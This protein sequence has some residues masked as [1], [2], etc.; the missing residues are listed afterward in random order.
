MLFLKSDAAYFAGQLLSH[1]EIQ[2]TLEY[3]ANRDLLAFTRSGAR[4]VI[5]SE[6][7]NLVIS[8]GLVSDH[9]ENKKSTTVNHNYNNYNS[10]GNMQGEINNSTQINLQGVDS[11]KFLAL[12]D[13]VL[14]QSTALGLP[15]QRRVELERLAGELNEEA[16]SE[17]AEPGRLRHLTRQIKEALVV[18]GTTSAATAGVALA[19]GALSSIL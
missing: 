9:T 7:A 4:V 12:A 8:G 1:E 5:R 14:N 2:E 11:S 19:E 16:S 15:E 10:H 17:T 6:G 18:M 13:Y 3:L